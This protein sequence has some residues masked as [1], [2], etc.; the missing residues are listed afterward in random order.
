MGED[1]YPNTITDLLRRAA[2]DHPFE[3]ACCSRDAARNWVPTEWAALWDQVKRVAASLRALGL[4]KG[5]RLAIVA[6]PSQHWL[7]A[8]MAGLYA[9]AVIVGID[10]LISAKQASQIIHQCG[11]RFL[12]ADNQAR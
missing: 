1:W 7:L 8:E 11:A 6:G 3:I 2:D 9:G 4:Q 10:P 5:D 12:I